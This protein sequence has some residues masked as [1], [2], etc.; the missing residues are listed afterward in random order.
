VE[1]GRFAATVCVQDL[2]RA[3]PPTLLS[4]AAGATLDNG[5]RDRFPSG[6]GALVWEFSW[7]EVAGATAYHLYVIGPG[8]TIPVIDQQVNSLSYRY[9]SRGSTVFSPNL[10]NWTWKMRSRVN[11]QWSE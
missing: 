10:K 9:V 2:C 5:P 7:S 11:G 4:P 1:V 6:R 3:V 8:A